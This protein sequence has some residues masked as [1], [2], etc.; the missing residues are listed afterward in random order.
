MGRCNARDFSCLLGRWG[1]LL[2]LKYLLCSKCCGCW[3]FHVVLWSTWAITVRIRC[4]IL[5]W[6]FITRWMRVCG[7]LAWG[8]TISGWWILQFRRRDKF[9]WRCR[10]ILYVNR[11]R[12]VR[13]WVDTNFCWLLFWL[14]YRGVYFF[15]VRRWGWWFW[16]CTSCWLVFS[17]GVWIRGWRCRRGEGRWRIVFRV[18]FGWVARWISLEAC[19]LL[20]VPWF[21]IL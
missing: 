21:Q 20:T 5:L 15:S 1:D 13:G 2:V 7:F 8:F 10:S 17:G 14:F 12:S 6:L 11:F 19:R 3:C 18:G 4:S 9:W 16:G